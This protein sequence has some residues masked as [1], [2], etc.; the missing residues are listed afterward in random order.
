MSGSAA[1]KDEKNSVS[2]MKVTHVWAPLKTYFTQIFV[3]W[4]DWMSF[5]VSQTFN[6]RSWKFRLGNTK[7]PRIRI[8]LVILTDTHYY[9]SFMVVTF[10][11][12]CPFIIFII[13]THYSIKLLNHYLLMV[14]NNGTLNWPDLNTIFSILC[15]PKLT[16]NYFYFKV[17]SGFRD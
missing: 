11:S 13:T 14:Y 16:R 5:S 3:I 12:E 1:K 9:H 6:F 4:Q 17:K 2:R 15:W 8:L 10:T 7:F